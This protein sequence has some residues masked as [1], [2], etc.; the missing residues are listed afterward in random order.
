MSTA[1]SEKDKF[2]LNEKSKGS[3]YIDALDKYKILVPGAQID[4]VA[5]MNV[6]NTGN[7]PSRWS[8]DGLSGLKGSGA[9]SSLGVEDPAG[10]VSA[11]DTAGKPKANANYYK[12]GGQHM[13]QLNE[14]GNLMTNTN[15]M[16]DGAFW[17]GDNASTG[18]LGP[19]IG[20][21][22]MLAKTY[23][24]YQELQATKKNNEEK[25]ALMKE[26][27]F[28]KKL[29]MKNQVNQANRYAAFGMGNSN[30]QTAT[31]ASAAGTPYTYMNLA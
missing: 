1:M 14:G 18:V 22:N 30:N 17:F 5:T 7:A 23:L 6:W 16:G 28:M 25:L 3:S 11:T 15:S 8:F 21:A 31:V 4:E 9:L 12:Q 20:A 26:A 13:V 27:N 10:D 29:K 19:T 24:G 2:F